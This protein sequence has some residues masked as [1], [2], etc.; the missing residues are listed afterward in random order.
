MQQFTTSDLFWLEHIICVEWDVKSYPANWL[1]R[2]V[3][4]SL[5]VSNE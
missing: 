2:A 4:Q 3:S 5:L 1:Q